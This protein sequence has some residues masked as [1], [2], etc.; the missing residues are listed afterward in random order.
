MSLP[1]FA[2]KHKAIVVTFVLV[3]MLWGVLSYQS[4]PRREVP[5]YTVSTCTVT[6]YWPGASVEK[7]EELISLS[8]TTFLGLFIGA[9]PD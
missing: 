6:V 7:I 2:L 5:E 8:R 1:G 3:F 9:A 4:M